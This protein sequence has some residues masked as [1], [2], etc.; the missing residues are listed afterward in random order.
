MD[1]D[2]ISVLVIDHEAKSKQQIQKLLK[3]NVQVSEIEFVE[4]PNEAILKIISTSPDLLII[5]YP[6][7]GPAEDELFSFVRTKLPEVVTIFTASTQDY[8]KNAIQYGVYNYLLR[9]IDSEKLNAIIVTTA[10]K[11]N[12]NAQSRVNRMVASLSDSKIKIVTLNG[13]FIINIDELIFC[14]SINFVTEIFLTGLRKEITHAPT[15]KLEEKL[16][17]HN[18]IRVTRNHLI[19]PRFIKRYYKKGNILTLSAD[20]LEYDI[21]VSK[22]YSKNLTKFILE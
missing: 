11:K 3:S 20:G 21:L 13:Y 22:L 10:D 1:S 7:N 12:S 18:F 9:P 15:T 19:N 6:V 8:A 2:K 17:E 14:S 16:I 4:T 5:N